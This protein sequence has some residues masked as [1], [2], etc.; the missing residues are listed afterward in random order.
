MASDFKLDAYLRRIGF[1]GAPRPDLETLTQAHARHVD[2][3]A[4]EALDPF[5]GRPVSL[6]MDDLQA[7]L[8]ASRRGGYCF[9]QNALFRGALTAIGFEV[10]SLAGRVTWMSPPDAPLG[11]RTHMLLRVTLPEGVFLADVGFGAHLLDAPLAFLPD[12][13]QRS[14]AAT[15]RIETLGERYGLA[16]LTPEGWRRAYVFDLQPQLDSDYALGNFFTANS[17]EAP[18]RRTLILE[19]LTRTCRINLVDLSLRRR[20]RDGRAEERAIADPADLAQ[21]FDK[22][23]DIVP[24]IPPEEIFA[25]LARL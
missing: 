2:A 6:A 3:I 20:W 21:V 11:P 12:T 4:F 24:P 25:R 19:R 1:I 17:Q 16:V 7:K 13:V 9:E 14:P 5:A 22:D 8:V 15:W 10:E 18:F 23:F